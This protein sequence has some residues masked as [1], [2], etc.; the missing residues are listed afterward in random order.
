MRSK[1]CRSKTNPQLTALDR[2]ERLAEQIG[3]Q[4]GDALKVFGGSDGLTQD[5]VGLE[6][7]AHFVAKEGMKLCG[8]VKMRVEAAT[9]RLDGDERADQEH[10][11]GGIVEMVGPDDADQVAK[12]NAQVDGVERQVGISRDEFGDIAAE[13][14][15]IDVVA[16]DVERFEG[17]DHAIG[18]L[19]QQA[20]QA[21]RRSARAFACRDVRRCHSRAGR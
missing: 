12:E 9:D 2:F 13:A 10:E 1:P 15:G 16:A 11:I 7:S 6:S 4:G 8:D 17:A 18:I 19:R 20:A 3:N 5:P 21:G 14:A